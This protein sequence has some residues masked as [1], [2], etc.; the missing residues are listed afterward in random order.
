[1]ITVLAGIGERPGATTLLSRSTP[2]IGSAGNPGQRQRVP[3]A[4]I[5]ASVRLPTR[6][7]EKQPPGS[8][9][10]NAMLDTNDG[11]P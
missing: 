1:M 2:I 6:L 8:P 11:D 5:W 10:N 7:L 3:L 9:L 4:A